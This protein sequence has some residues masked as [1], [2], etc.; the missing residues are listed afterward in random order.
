LS[1]D[2][3]KTDAY[4]GAVKQEMRKYVGGAVL[5]VGHQRSVPPLIEAY[6]GPK[7]PIICEN[8]FENLFVLSPGEGGKAH[9]VHSRYGAINPTSA[10]DCM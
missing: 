3:T 5:V 10:P 6:G 1:F 7:L 4:V 8:R 2:R 9:L